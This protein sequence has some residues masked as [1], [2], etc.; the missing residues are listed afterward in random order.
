ML[1][2]QETVR[3]EITGTTGKKIPQNRGNFII[4]TPPN[5]IIVIKSSTIRLARRVAG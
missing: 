2:L 5:I 1:Q 4:Y 3:K